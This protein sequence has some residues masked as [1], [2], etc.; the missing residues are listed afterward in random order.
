MGGRNAGV[1]LGPT[2][3]GVVLVLVLSG[4]ASAGTF[5][6]AGAGSRTGAWSA[7]ETTA[8]ELSVDPSVVSVRAG[9][10]AEFRSAWTGIPPGC[11]GTPL[12]FTW[13]VPLGS[14]GGYPSPT[15]GPFTN[16]STS[17]GISGAS[18]LEVRS[19]LEL[20][21]SGTQRVTEGS[22]T[23]TVWVDL[24]LELEDLTMTPGATVPG[25]ES[26]LTGYVAGGSPPYRIDVGWGDGN[27]SVLEVD[28]SGRFSIPEN[29]PT[30]SFLPVVNVSDAAGGQANGTA[31]DPIV[32]SAATVAVLDASAGGLEPGAATSI[33]ATIVHPSSD[34]RFVASCGTAST[35]GVLTGTSAI[36]TVSFPCVVTD[37]Q[38]VARFLAEPFPVTGPTLQAQLQEA[39]TE[40]LT[41]RAAPGLSHVEVGV[42]SPLLVAIG[43]GA[44]PFRVLWNASGTKSPESTT[45]LR[46]GTTS[47]PYVPMAPAPTNLT[48]T[49]VDALDVARSAT[50][51]L[52][53]AS[54]S[55]SINASSSRSPTPQGVEIA[56]SATAAGGALP[57]SW[58]IIAS[59]GPNDS[60]DVNGSLA[61]DGSFG[62]N[63]TAEGPGTASVWIAAVDADGVGSVE[64]LSQPL[65]P[66]LEVSALLWAMTNGSDRFVEVGAAIAGGLP[67]FEIR[68][69]SSANESWNWTAATD[70]GFSWQLPTNDSGTVDFDLTVVDAD[71]EGWYEN[72]SLEYPGDNNT[73]ASPPPDGGSPPSGAAPAPASASPAAPWLIL[74]GV[75]TVILLG[76]LGGLWLYRRR[77]RSA[78]PSPPP[79]DPVAVIREIVEPAEGAE[80]STVELLAEEQGLPLATVRSTI[81]RLVSDGTLRSETGSDG[82]EVLAWSELS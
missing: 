47:I 75:A 80:R 65:V 48:I 60:A 77:R 36:E 10:P 42:P 12:W 24:P 82:E 67:P 39:L 72:Q 52:P 58:W 16:F 7:A 78:E 41:V 38:P 2:D 63:G 15:E 45:V 21:C 71:G 66:P 20:D 70:G 51:V 26:N 57:I 23:A 62:W 5:G 55:L 4:V 81:D 43:G 1:R 74:A 53:G 56:A 18:D 69:G 50:L 22:A 3:I 49:V 59:L 14:E 13:G 79:P 40:P 73:S 32:V 17:P 61:D 9:S 33:A 34:Y 6:A 76:I 44:A 29:F 64:T 25:R 54:P 19:A 30:G 8:V 68:L 35:S 11:S 37:Q 46:D 27:G 31:L 28:R